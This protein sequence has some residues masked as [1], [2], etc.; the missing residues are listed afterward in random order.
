[1][2]IQS[3]G[4]VF[5]EAK[6]RIWDSSSIEGKMMFALGGILLS[7]YGMTYSIARLGNKTAQDL[8]ASLDRGSVTQAAGDAFEKSMETGAGKT[9]VTI[10]APGRPDEKFEVIVK[11]LNKEP[12]PGK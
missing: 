2:N 12:A 3:I 11:R 6:K 9:T 8:L 5:R 7:G 4:T 10:S 1:M